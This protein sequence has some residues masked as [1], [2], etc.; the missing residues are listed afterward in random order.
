[1]KRKKRKYTL[2]LV[3]LLVTV[4]I[5][6]GGT[7]AYLF[8]E[9]DPVVNTFTPVEV[10]NE[11][12]EVLNG[13]VKENVQIKNT[14]TTDAFIRAK[15]VVTWQNKAG[16]VYPIMPVAPADGVTNHDYTISY[17]DNW[18]LGDDGYFYYT[19][20]VSATDSTKVLISSVTPVQSCEDNTYTLHV[21]ILSQ[22]IQSTPDIAVDVW[23]NDKVDVNGT[24]GTLTVTNQINTD[25]SVTQSE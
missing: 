12:H 23:D 11:I 19:K 20:S 3:C 15:V 22:A 17:G 14:G 18:I 9:S 6:V 7:I 21:E 4:S 24:N 2:M 5:V 13:N 25:E 8:T 1:M 10:D 16:V